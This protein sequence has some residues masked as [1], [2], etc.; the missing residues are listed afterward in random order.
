[1]YYF[2]P[3]QTVEHKTL[4]KVHFGQWMRPTTD[5]LDMVDVIVNHARQGMRTVRVNVGS[6]A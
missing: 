3:M 4:G 5:R 1:M 2:E 6:L